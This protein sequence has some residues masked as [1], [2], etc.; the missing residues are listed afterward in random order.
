MKIKPLCLAVAVAM[1]G[2]GGGGGSGSPPAAPASPST[3]SLSGS[4]VKGPLVNA[5]VRAYSLDTSAADLKG[6]LLGS[7]STNS[8]AALTGLAIASSTTGP[9]LLEIV[10]D[11]DTVDLTTGA[12]PVITRMTT[13][14]DAALLMAGDVY[15]TPLT[16]MVVEL[17][18]KNG[19][20]NTL[21]Y[22]GNNDSNL[23]EA[24]F[25]AALAVAQGQ[26]K[27]S[28]GLGL[29]DD[30]DLLAQTPLITSDTS[31]A[32]AQTAV[33]NYRTAIEGVAAIAE[34]LKD[35]AVAANSGSTVS[36]DDMFAALASD[37]SDGAIDGQDDSGALTAMADVPD[38]SASVT[39]SPATL[40]IPGTSTPLTDVSDVL[41]AE[42]EDT[43][44]DTDTTSIENAD[45][46]P[47]VVQTE[48]DSDDDGVPDRSDAFPADASETTDTDGDGVGDNADVFPDDA[49]ETADFDGDQ[50]G[51]NAD[52]D[53][54]NDGT[55]DLEDA[56]PF[57]D[58]EDADWDE[59]GE[60]D[61][62]DL[63]DDNDGTPDLQDAFPNNANEQAD[64]DQDGT[65]DN[66]DAF[67]T[68]PTEQ[69]DTDEDGVGDNADQ[70]PED[71]TETVDSDGD[72]TGDNADA[73]PNDANEQTD[74]DGD[75]V[76]DGSDEFPNDASEQV[77][78]DGDGVG[79][80]SDAFPNDASETA[81]SDG[82]QVGDNTDN[83]VNAA[84]PNQDDSDEDGIG[85][86]CEDDAQSNAAT[87]DQFDWDDG[88]TWQ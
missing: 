28:L 26:V 52:T 88:S 35:D 21:G 4:A 78:S 79:D 22:S 54:D 23:T 12:A 59:D 20:K 7:G 71:A 85:D 42:T 25:L 5:V 17:A 33:L 55:P 70:F 10:A 30:I 1:T 62:A 18:R 19:N 29:V 45:T 69:V 72:G 64:S 82:D 87:W 57:D 56:F 60:G 38:V 66:A 34:K 40:M 84:N 50:T 36:T 73:F 63:D 27:S 51:D 49:T 58:G 39:V 46:T 75:G 11:G 3:T 77:D 16:T 31:D 15:A 6:D 81:D 14:R 44:I 68:D 86:V 48:P 13:V 41:V 74:T 43:G 32:S 37:L 76:G 2:C 65:G 8:Q 47:E 67:P 80:N 53:D 61:N 24:E 83:C 9:V